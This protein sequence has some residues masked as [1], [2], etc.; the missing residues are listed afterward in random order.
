MSRLGKRLALL[1]A[2]FLIIW[3]PCCAPERA[4]EPVRQ[5]VIGLLYRIRHEDTTMYLLGSIHIGSKAM[6]PFGTAIRQGMEEADIFVFE[7]DTTSLEAAVATRSAMALPEGGKLHDFISMECYTLLEEVCRLKGYSIGRMN[8]LRPWA[9]MTTL[10]MDVTASEIGAESAGE[11]IALGVERNVR[12]FAR[13]Q[14]KRIVYLETVREQLDALDHLSLPLQEHL[15]RE[16][17]RIIKDPSL[18]KGLDADISLWP[19][20]WQAGDEKAFA[21]SYQRGYQ[22]IADEDERA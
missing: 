19:V 7:C 10:A 2:G 11:A 5:E 18:A 15:L 14:G 17:L 21:D 8:T 16:Q 13:E 4:N 22:D 9:A 12:A 20:F 3:L 6:H 1:M